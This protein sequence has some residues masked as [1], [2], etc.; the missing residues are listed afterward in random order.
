MKRIQ[1]NVVTD[2]DVR[3]ATF[4]AARKAVSLLFGSKLGFFRILDLLYSVF[5]VLKN[6]ARH[7]SA[8]ITDRR[9]FTDP[10]SGCLVSIRQDETWARASQSKAC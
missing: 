6:S 7:N 4:S 8:V 2:L 1:D 10:P 9:K 3:I 5:G